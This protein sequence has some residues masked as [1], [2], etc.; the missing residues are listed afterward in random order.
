MNARDAFKANLPQ[1][2]VESVRGNVVADAEDFTSQ[3][4]RDFVSFK[5]AHTFGKDGV[6]AFIKVMHEAGKVYP[7]KGDYVEV[8]GQ[9]TESENESKGVTYLNRTI[10]ASTIEILG[11]AAENGGTEKSKSATKSKSK[12]K[13]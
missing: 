12:A 2:V 11:A 3:G 5:I 10:F 6:T 4:G 8:S 13:R 9:Y 1:F 7:L